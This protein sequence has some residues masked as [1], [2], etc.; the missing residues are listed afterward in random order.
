[1]LWADGGRNI[2]W[3]DKGLSAIDPDYRETHPSPGKSGTGTGSVQSYQVWGD[4]MIEGK[5]PGTYEDTVIVT[6]VWN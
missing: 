2:S 6:I 5:R 4:A 1:T 3:G